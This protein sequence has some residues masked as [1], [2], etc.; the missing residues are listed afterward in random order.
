M[1]NIGASHPSLSILIHEDQKSSF[2]NAYAKTISS[3]SAS[4]LADGMW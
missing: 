3:S 4:I 2:N 1:G